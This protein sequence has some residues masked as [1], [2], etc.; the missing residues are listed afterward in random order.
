MKRTTKSVLV[1]ALTASMVFGNAGVSN[2]A[3]AKK[4]KLSKTK[5]TITVGKKKKITVKKAKPKKT[6]WSVN[7]KGKKIVRKLVKLR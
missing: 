3:K 1:F 5:V 6:K 2:A 7:K 4:P